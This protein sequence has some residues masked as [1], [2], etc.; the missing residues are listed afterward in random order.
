[1]K[2]SNHFN[3]ML[4]KLSIFTIFDPICLEDINTA[5]KG[6]GFQDDARAIANDWKVVGDDI[7]SILPPETKG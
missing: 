5:Y 4:S 7:R 1:M 3:Q 2:L 6:E